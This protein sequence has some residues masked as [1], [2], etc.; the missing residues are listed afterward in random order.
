MRLGLLLA[1]ALGSV[2]AVAALFL[3]GVRVGED[4][5][6]ARQKTVLE[7]VDTAIKARDLQTADLLSKIEV[8][9]VQLT[10]PVL[11]EIR[12]NTVYRDC[13]HDPR[14]LQAVN[15]AIVGRTQPAGGGQLPPTDP[16][17]K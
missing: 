15:D 14:G 9:N 8:K 7:A 1:A 13:V 16:P 11:H 10:Q 5:A 3:Y 4:R 6:T 12:T 2:A 17:G